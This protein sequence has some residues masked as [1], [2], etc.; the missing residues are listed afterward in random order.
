M[1]R[2]AK[3]AGA[4]EKPPATGRKKGPNGTQHKKVKQKTFHEHLQTKVKR[5]ESSRRLWKF[6]GQVNSGI[7][8]QAAAVEGGGCQLSCHWQ[9]SHTTSAISCLRRQLLS[10]KYLSHFS[11]AG[12]NKLLYKNSCR[13][14]LPY[15]LLY[16]TGSCQH[17]ATAVSKQLL[18]NVHMYIVHSQ[19]A[20]RNPLSKSI[21]A[22]PCQHTKTALSTA[23]QL[24][25]TLTAVCLFEL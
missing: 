23:R 3:N 8:R 22:K 18:Y 24:S 14:Q 21:V 5:Y 9:L 2:V 10:E 17:H 16:C 7:F 19:T 1:Y 6:G 20:V 12:S 4:A 15:S 11:T 13:N 25:H